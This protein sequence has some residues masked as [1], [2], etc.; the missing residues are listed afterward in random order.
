MSMTGQ[1][2]NQRAMYSSK[3]RVGDYIPS[4]SHFGISWW[5]S[6]TRVLLNKV[7]KGEASILFLF[8]M[9]FLS[10]KLSAEQEML[11]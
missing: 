4:D 5:L 9:N 1:A 6:P 2:Q 11:P 7:F 3:L 8:S 10:M